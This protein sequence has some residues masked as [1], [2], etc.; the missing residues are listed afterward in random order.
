MHKDATEATK[1]VIYEELLHTHK[2]KSSEEGTSFYWATSIPDQ[3]Q[4]R[5]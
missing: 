2:A 1:D 4:T 3:G 5:M